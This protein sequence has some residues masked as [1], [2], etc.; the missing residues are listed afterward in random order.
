MSR[1]PDR[2]TTHHCRYLHE[3]GRL[4]DHHRAVCT[5]VARQRVVTILAE[6]PIGIS[7]A[8][9]TII[10]RA[11]KKRIAPDIALEPVDTASTIELI[12]ARAAGD[13]VRPLSAKIV[14]F[15]TVPM[16]SNPRAASWP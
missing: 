6:E 8:V 11:A 12:M 10:A 4:P 3:A 2:Q 1:S 5:G 7:A 9:S 14:S 13:A 15:S 16:R